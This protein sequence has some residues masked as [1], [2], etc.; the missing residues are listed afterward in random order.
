MPGIEPHSSVI[1]FFPDCVYVCVAGGANVANDKYL[2]NSYLAF[3]LFSISYFLELFK[4]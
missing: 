4:H 2:C 1:S 3:W